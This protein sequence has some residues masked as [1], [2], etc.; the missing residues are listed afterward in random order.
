MFRNLYVTCIK[1]YTCAVYAQWHMHSVHF[2]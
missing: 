1:K 2:L